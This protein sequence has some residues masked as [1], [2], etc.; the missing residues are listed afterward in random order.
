MLRLNCS[1]LVDRCPFVLLIYI[2]NIIHKLKI[3]TFGAVSQKAND[4][5]RIVGNSQGFRGVD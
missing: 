5:F 1:A 3:F 4:R 2:A